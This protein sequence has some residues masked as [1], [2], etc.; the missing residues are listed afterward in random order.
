MRVIWMLATCLVMT[1]G[2]G[3][4]D[5]HVKQFDVENGVAIDVLKRMAEGS[6]G[7]ITASGQG[8]EPGWTVE[9]GTKWYASAYYKGLSGQFAVGAAGSLK[10]LTP[11]QEATVDKVIRDKALSDEEKRA[12]ILGILNR[13]TDAVIAK[14]TATQ[15]SS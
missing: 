15:P 11:E 13:A 9:A 3:L 12:A 6:V 7:Q 5:S 1:S 2:C 4:L 14:N 10:T 8:I